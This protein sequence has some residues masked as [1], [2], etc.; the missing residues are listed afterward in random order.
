MNVPP[1][2]LDGE[3]NSATVPTLI[4]TPPQEINLTVGVYTGLLAAYGYD[5]VLCAGPTLFDSS[6]SS[7]F[8]VRTYTFFYTVVSSTQATLT[9][10]SHYSRQIP[11]GVLP[12][13]RS[14]GQMLM[15]P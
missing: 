5:C 15:I 1:Y 12:S 14:T 10:H 13:R 2:L 8:N 6:L 3:F 11:L 4:G 7:T 9:R